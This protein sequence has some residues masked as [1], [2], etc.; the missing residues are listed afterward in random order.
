M[1]G[2]DQGPPRVGFKRI[3]ANPEDRVSTWIWSWREEERESV[4]AGTSPDK[5]FTSMFNFQRQNLTR[6]KKR[7]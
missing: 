7:K 1:R 4:S 6:V 5:S 2:R 3:S